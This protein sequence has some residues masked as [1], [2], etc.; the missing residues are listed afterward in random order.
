MSYNIIAGEVW[1]FLLCIRTAAKKEEPAY[2]RPLQ[3][4]IWYKYVHQMDAHKYRLQDW[5]CKGGFPYISP[6]YWFQ[7]LRRG[8]QVLRSGSPNSSNGLYD[9]DCIPDVV[10]KSLDLTDLGFE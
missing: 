8:S 10:S 2:R 6:F 4:L 7:L 1:F 9:T 3:T 5:R